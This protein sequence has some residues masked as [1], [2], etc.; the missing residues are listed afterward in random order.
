M[1]PRKS[2]QADSVSRPVR[3]AILCWFMSTPSWTRFG[4]RYGGFEQHEKTIAPLRGLNVHLNEKFKVAFCEDNQATIHI[5]QT[6]NS[7][8]F[9]ML[10]ELKELLW[11]GFENNSQKVSSISST[12]TLCTQ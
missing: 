4:T 6:G 5:I 11:R 9:V 7:A 2:S 3:G 12:S 8:S 10:T 1:H